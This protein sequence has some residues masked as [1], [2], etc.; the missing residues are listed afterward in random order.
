MNVAGAPRCCVIVV[1]M[2]SP[3]D[4]LDPVPVPRILWMNGDEAEARK[5]ADTWCQA[6][7]GEP[8]HIMVIDDTRRAEIVIKGTKP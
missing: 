4:G 6:H 7:L 1:E 2:A 3:G 8:A 5:V